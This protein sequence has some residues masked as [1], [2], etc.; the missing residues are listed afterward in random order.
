[1]AD[2]TQMAAIFVTLSERR[3]PTKSSM[4]AIA[5]ERPVRGLSWGTLLRITPMLQSLGLGG[6]ALM[7]GDAE[8]GA[9]AV[10]TLGALVL[11]R[12]LVRTGA[13]VLGLLFADTAF[14]TGAAA[15]SNLADLAT[16]SSTIGPAVLAAIA[17]T[18]AVA[19]I[20]TVWQGAKTPAPTRTA[21]LIALAMVATLA[22]VAIVSLVS[23]GAAAR[24]SD[25]P[26]RPAPGP[27]PALIRLEISGARFSTD[28][29]SA[30]GPTVTVAVTN[31]DL[32]WHTFTIGELGVDLRVPVGD[33]K[34][35]TFHAPPGTY[36]YI[37][38][39]PGHASFMRGVLTVR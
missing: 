23:S 6:A 21:T 14:F 12:F 25:V 9:I 32:F 30:T 10:V 2:P 13:I 26:A 22:V 17:L 29:L 18:G 27:A 31:H 28:A 11:Q 36:A 8:A 39:I 24:G 15:L 1:M 7:L 3:R 16:P 5:I 20:A 38:G 33:E 37:C 35:V 34:T 19:S 4:T